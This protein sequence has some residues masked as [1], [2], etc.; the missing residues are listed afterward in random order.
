MSGTV[1]PILAVVAAALF[2]ATM[3]LAAFS[4]TRIAGEY[5]GTGF[6]LLLLPMVDA[7]P[8]SFTTKGAGLA[9]IACD[10]VAATGAI[11]RGREASKRDAASWNVVRMAGHLFAAIWIAAASAALGTVGLVTGWLLA[12]TFAAFTLA[13]G[14]LP[15]WTMAVP[16]A[17]MIGWLLLVAYYFQEIA[18]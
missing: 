12:S 13:A 15:R 10:V 18:S 8:G 4:G 16:G 6:H 5:V 11:W 7:L 17:L 3:T 9:W 1:L 14:R 2:A